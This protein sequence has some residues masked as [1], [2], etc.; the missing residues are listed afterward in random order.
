MT[1]ASAVESE[2]SPAG[3]VPVRRL[4]FLEVSTNRIQA[5]NPDGSD[6][7]SYCYGLSAPDGVAIDVHASHNQCRW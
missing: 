1:D 5:M 3:E 2:V 4:L 7:N 6:R